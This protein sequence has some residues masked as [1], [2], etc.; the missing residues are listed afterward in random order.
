MNAGHNPPLLKRT[1]GS[2][3][4]L[5][6]RSGPPLAVMDGVRYRRHV[7][8]LAPG[9]GIV[10]YTDGVTEATDPSK[11]LYGEDRLVGAM[12]GLLG[13]HDAGAIIDGI[14]RDVVSF[15]SG[16]EQADDITLLAFKLLAKVV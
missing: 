15:A 12:R 7:L 1:S 13:A 5:T 10:L 6:D 14:V 9:D 16:A 2:V 11:A 8:T 4:Y 3:E